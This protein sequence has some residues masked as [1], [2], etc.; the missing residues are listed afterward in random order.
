MKVRLT[1]AAF[2]FPLMLLASGDPL[3]TGARNSAMGFSTAALPGLWS[4]FANR[5]ALAENP[6]LEVGFYYDN[7]F[8]TRE[9]AL[10][11]AAFSIPA[12]QG[13]FAVSYS[14]FGFDQYNDQSVGLSF[15]RNFGP[16]V[17]VGLGFNYLV[18]TL[19]G[20]YDKR[21]GFT[22]S[23][24]LRVKLSRAWTLG[25]YV[26]NPSSQKMSGLSE[27]TI[28]S[29][30]STGLLWNVAD[31]WLATAEVVKVTGYATEI[32]L[33]AEYRLIRQVYVRGGVAT[34]PARYTFGAGLN[35]GRLRIDLSSS[36]HSVLGYSPQISLQWRF[37]KQ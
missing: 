16:K 22:F 36:V 34:G 24:G 37:S 10:K 31:G 20:D 2:L 17:Q 19:A 7:R 12:W 15:G 35:T 27:E 32:H 8:M 21:T 33:G 4:A 30:M 23:A 14:H 13:A 28:P 3:V 25:A 18:N 5:A 9:M 11:T 1:F 26:D 29:R 6:S